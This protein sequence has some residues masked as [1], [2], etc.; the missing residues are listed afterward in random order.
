MVADAGFWKYMSTD[1][2]GPEALIESSP[3][4]L[5]RGDTEGR[6]VFLNRAQREFWGIDVADLANFQWSTTLLA[7]DQEEVFGPFSH[8]MET[9]QAFTCEARYWRADGEIRILRTKA[10]PV[11]AE[12][13][14]F[15]GMV[16]VNEDVTDL[17]EV[18]TNLAE[19]NNKLS[20]SLSEAKAATK[21]FEL[22]SQISGLSM[23]EHDKDLRYTWGHNLPGEFLGLT[24]KEFIGG[25]VGSE[26][27]VILASVMASGKPAELEINFLLDGRRRW[28]EIQACILPSEDDDPRL[29]ASAMDVTARKLNE[30][31]LEVLSRELGHRMKNFHSLT[32]ALLQQSAR[33]A[34]VD[35]TFT[36]TMS[37]RLTAL[38][39]A[40]DKLFESTNDRVAVEEIVK[41]HLGHLNRISAS[42]D[43]ATVLGK[44][45]TY[46]SLALHELGTNA[47]KYGALSKD[48]GRVKLTWEKDDKG[49]VRIF[50]EEDCALDYEISEKEGFGTSLLTRI[51]AAVTNGE[52][53]REFTSKGLRWSAT[54]PTAPVLTSDYE[55]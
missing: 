46:L 25:E 49:A 35:P 36:Q 19:M 22:A 3:A 23:S 29:L 48:E 18:Q 21:R 39:Q 42:G 1:D 13:G 31:K 52:T 24:P 14:R 37:D 9:Q 7:E 28:M 27:E 45:V 47:L 50:W 43:D 2:M 5:W 12:D 41:T 17:R 32:Q 4:M 54:I 55:T 10:T 44:S 15:Q 38:S 30:T 33:A 40:Q 8:G 6:C 34:N 26:V 51:F 20:A 16:G 53:T 11:F